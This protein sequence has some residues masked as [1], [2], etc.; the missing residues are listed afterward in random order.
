MFNQLENWSVNCGSLLHGQIL[1]LLNFFHVYAKNAGYCLIVQL[2]IYLA[3]PGLS[4][5][6]D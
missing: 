1:R 6:D 2:H 3:G 5:H 4:S